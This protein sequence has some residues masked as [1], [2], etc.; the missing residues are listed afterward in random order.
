MSARTARQHIR[1]LPASSVDPGTCLLEPVADH[2]EPLQ[3]KLI[4]IIAQ[5]K[6]NIKLVLSNVRLFTGCVVCIVYCI[7]HLA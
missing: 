6:D 7:F 1:G 2:V 5:L 3:F 4:N